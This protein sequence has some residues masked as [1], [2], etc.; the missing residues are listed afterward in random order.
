MAAP[1]IEIPRPGPL[2]AGSKAYDPEH[3]G[4][5]YRAGWLGQRRRRPVASHLCGRGLSE[6]RGPLAR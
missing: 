4:T 5:H 3:V 1:A 6:E 2:G